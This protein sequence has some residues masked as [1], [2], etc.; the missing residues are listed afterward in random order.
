MQCQTRRGLGNL[1]EEHIQKVMNEIKTYQIG[2]LCFFQGTPEKQANLTNQYQKLSKIPLMVSMDAEWGLSMRLKESTITFPKQM[3][4]GAIQD[5]NLIYRFGVA[6]AKE[7]KRLGVQVNFA[8]DAD[9]NNNPR[10]PVINERSFGE[11]KFN[12]AAI[13]EGH[14]R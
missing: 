3:M 11:D 13:Y 10:N 14:A 6:I 12:V 7:C 8:P 4:L 2:G 5:N 1:G 9:V